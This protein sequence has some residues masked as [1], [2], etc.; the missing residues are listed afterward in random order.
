MRNQ[1]ESRLIFINFPEISPSF[2][3]HLL[4]CNKFFCYSC[5]QNFSYFIH[6]Q[7]CFNLSKRIVTD[8]DAICDQNL[9]SFSFHLQAS[10]VLVCFGTEEIM[11]PPSFKQLSSFSQACHF[12]HQNMGH[13][14]SLCVY[15][16]HC[17][18]LS[19]PE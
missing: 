17:F 4:Y 1:A 5:P 16:C 11:P 2:N 12:I 8:K 10:K 7:L 19:R 18:Q 13:L 6:R 9:C 3:P 14:V 15:N